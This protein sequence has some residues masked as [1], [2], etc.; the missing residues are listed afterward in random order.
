MLEN[1]VLAAAPSQLIEYAFAIADG[2][3]SP[4]TIRG[5]RSILKR[6][7]A[8]C[9]QTERTAI[10]ADG[11][12]IAIY[13]S[14]QL[15]DLSLASSRV[16]LAA[17][18]FVHRMNDL[19][20]PTRSRPVVLARKRIARAKTSRPRQVRG[21]SFA[22]LQRILNACP[23]TLIGKR[24]AAV[25][26][27]GYDSLCRVSELARMR[28]DDVDFA[29]SEIIVPRAKN[30]PVGKGRV[31]HLSPAALSRLI[32]WLDAAGI[33]EGHLFR[34]LTRKQL[35]KGPMDTGSLRRLIKSAGARANLGGESGGAKLSGHSLRVGAAQDLVGSGASLSAIMRL[36]GWSDP[37]VL[38]RYGES[39]AMDRFSSDR[40]RRLATSGRSD[41]ANLAQ[42]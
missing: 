15:A 14:T 11:E 3:Y 22:M 29:A 28:I 37:A 4:S 24:D 30:D 38:A 6:Y 2:A 18:T 16:L 23:D 12:T 13:L 9:V 20:I 8:W 34:S 10:P 5:Y 1:R 32:I 33:D 17:I 39:A 31:V 21:I 19:P 40:W 25:L 26:S 7:C 41:P 35:G 27:V 42:T 36:G